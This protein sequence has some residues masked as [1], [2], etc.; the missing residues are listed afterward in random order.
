MTLIVYANDRTI[1]IFEK[2]TFFKSV[3][4][5][6]LHRYIVIRFPETIGWVCLEMR[7]SIWF[8]QTKHF[9]F[10]ESIV[11]VILTLSVKFRNK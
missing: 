4:M 9:I 10:S 1:S 6:T 5:Y 8:S 7:P 3:S 2:Y 11:A